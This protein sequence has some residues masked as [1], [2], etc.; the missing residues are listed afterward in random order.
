VVF[1][2]EPESLRAGL[3]LGLLGLLMT[4]G[5]LALGILRHRRCQP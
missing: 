1:S 4:T 2:Y 3:G 5:T